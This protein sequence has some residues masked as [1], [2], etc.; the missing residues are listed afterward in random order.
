MLRAHL[1]PVQ[2][3]STNL[4]IYIEPYGRVDSSVVS[5]ARSAVRR[6]GAG[7]ELKR[8]GSVAFVMQMNREYYRPQDAIDLYRVAHR[9]GTLRGIE[10]CAIC[11]IEDGVLGAHVDISYRDFFS[12]VMLLTV[13]LRPAVC[14]I[15]CSHCYARPV[16]MNSDKFLQYY[17]REF[18]EEVASAV[19]DVV[20]KH[21]ADRYVNVVPIGGNTDPSIMC[22]GGRCEALHTHATIML[23]RLHDGKAL[24]GV[25]SLHVNL[26]TSVPTADMLYPILDALGGAVYPHVAERLHANRSGQSRTPP[27][28][29][30]VA[31]SMYTPRVRNR[32]TLMSEKTATY[33]RSRGIHIIP[34]IIARYEEL[35]R[36]LLYDALS[37]ANLYSVDDVFHP[38]VYILA[39]YPPMARLDSGKTT[40]RS[41]VSGIS[42]IIYLL[43]RALVDTCMYNYLFGGIRTPEYYKGR[44]YKV[45]ADWENK[46]VHVVEHNGTWCP[47]GIYTGTGCVYP[48]RSK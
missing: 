48:P 45:V 7:A 35:D 43:G 4:A 17:T 42:M 9:Y 26:S 25:R 41:V 38:P 15:G 39:P 44:Y 5:V 10:H 24:D 22:R 29:S 28:H 16:H 12:D 34:T 31:W 2:P 46:T 32:A 13:E 23:D 8:D 20:A 6:L 37:V 18:S 11:P 33:A 1:S 36:D 27:L 3:S 21:G 30:Y 40:Y 19:A 47:R 14:P